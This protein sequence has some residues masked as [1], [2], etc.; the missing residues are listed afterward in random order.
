MP[1]FPLVPPRRNLPACP[2]WAPMFPE[3]F[4]FCDWR[5]QCVSA[6]LPNTIQPQRPCCPPVRPVPPIGILPPMR[7][8]AR[9]MHRPPARPVPPIGNLR[10]PGVFR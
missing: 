9:P 10:P 2:C 4:Q 3:V 1:V 5:K 7:P 8:P 6:N